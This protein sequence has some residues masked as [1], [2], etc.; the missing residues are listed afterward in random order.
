VDAMRLCKILDI[1]LAVM[2]LSSFLL[3]NVA[4]AEDEI[5]N[6]VNASIDI[7]FVTGTNLNV[8]IAMDVYRLT[9]DKT[10]DAAGIKSASE[11]ELGAFRLKLYLMLEE[12]LEEIFA[13]ANMLNFTMPIFDGDKFNDDFNVELT[14]SFFNLNES[15]NSEN[16]INGV[17]DICAIVNYTFNLQTEQGW[18]NTYTIILPESIGYKQTTG[19]V[20]NNR[21]QW[22]V[23]NGDGEH[24][25]KLAEIS[26]KLED[27]TTSILETEDIQLEFV[28]DNRNEKQTILTTNILVKSID[29]GD[30]DIVPD[31]ITDLEIIPSDGFRLFVD[32]GLSS[33]EDLYNKTIKT[34]EEKA[35]LK[36][37]N[38]SF[39]QTLDTTF[40]W[41]NNTTADCLTPYETTNMD[42]N[43]PI[44]A[45]ST[46]SDVNLQICNISS[47]ALF[48][49]TN[50][51]AQANISANDINFGGNLDNIGYQFNGTLYLPNNLYLDGKNI[52]NWTQ[53]T[54]ISGKFESDIATSYSNEKID[55]LVEIE[56]SSTDLN[57]L[58]FFTGGTE[59]NLG[60]FLQE[61]RKYGVTAVPDEFSLPE[62][63]SLDYLNADAFRLC[64][65]EKVFGEED[66]TIFLNGEKQLFESRLMNILKLP[67]IDGYVDMDAFDKSLDW[68]EDIANMDALIP[69][70]VV[71]CAHNSYPVSFDISFLS[72]KF[73]ISHQSF[74]FTGIQSQNV[75]YKMI[76]PHGTTVVVND[77]LEKAVVKKTDDG[78]EYIEITF[79]TSE[80][81]LMDTVSCKIIPSALFIV[82]LF[83]PCI[84]SLIITI[85]LVVIIYII[86]KKRKRKRGMITDEDGREFDG[87]SGQDY[88]VPPPPSSKR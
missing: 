48:G 43:P 15:V 13:N 57:L 73:E 61:T 40:G 20:E 7:E 69:V 46:D 28:L 65:E 49:L 24:P 34:I 44:R 78:R 37:E 51:G 68:D 84:I 70:E 1:I 67:E 81:G 32:N 55:T 72:P 58:S 71:S 38:S 59:M 36:I 50:A 5:E 76:F 82:G 21:I 41:V 54:P 23:K 8:D 88:Y 45:T 63:I 47:R 87:Y 9:T 14:P 62:K 17:L 60:L 10:Y 35:I 29:I 52:Y 86:R 75:T 39:N 16:F 26:I 77:T 27:P 53:G 18:N 74:N 12:Q 33:W 85:I 79:D 64:M 80:F 31:F 25:S 83:I 6:K 56:V 42:S 22:E 4:I 2:L 19:S 3:V 11:Q 30:Y 66:T